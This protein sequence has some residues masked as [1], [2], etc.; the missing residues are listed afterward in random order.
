VLLIYT[1]NKKPNEI[2]D[3]TPVLQ[4]DLRF[5]WSRKN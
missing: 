3:K 1:L 2:N 4:K 5:K